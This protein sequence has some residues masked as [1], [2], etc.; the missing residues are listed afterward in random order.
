M[1]V[2]KFSTS[3]PMDDVLEPVGAKWFGQRRDV[4]AHYGVVKSSGLVM[5]SRWTKLGSQ[6][7]AL[8]LLGI[9]VNL[10]QP[11]CS[12]IWLCATWS[13]ITALSFALNRSDQRLSPQRKATALSSCRAGKFN[14]TRMM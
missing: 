4:H 5:L 9:A 13:T 1:P 12:P 14:S 10:L 8:W 3:S 11:A 2:D 7:V 6:I